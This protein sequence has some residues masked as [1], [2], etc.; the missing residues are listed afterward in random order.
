M[1][2]GIEISMTIKERHDDGF[3]F[4][5]DQFERVD[6]HEGGVTI[7]SSDGNYYEPLQTSLAELTKSYAKQGREN[8]S[9]EAYESL[10]KELSHYLNCY[11]VELVVRAYKCNVL[12]AEVSSCLF[13]FSYE[14]YDSLSELQAYIEKE[15][16]DW[17]KEKVMEEAQNKLKQL[18]G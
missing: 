6:K 7:Q 17:L 11:G 14:Y 4:F 16:G 9:R 13:E 8:P 10:Q 15:E 5:M 18:C 1:S 2:N 3:Y 12:L